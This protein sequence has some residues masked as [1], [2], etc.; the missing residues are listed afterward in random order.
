MQKKL[1]SDFKFL[2]YN[3]LED[4]LKI[5]LSSSQSALGINSLLY[6]I[7]DNNNDIL[8]IYNSSI[9]S[10]LIHYIILNEKPQKKF[11]QLNKINGKYEFINQLGT[12]SHSIYIPILE[13]E[14]LSIEFP[15]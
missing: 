5:I 9:G 6:H 4:M 8:F 10:S 13:L 7:K 1:A 3:N 2:K 14:K 11:I 12:E 15:S